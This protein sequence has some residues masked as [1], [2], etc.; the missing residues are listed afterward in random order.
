MATALNLASVTGKIS[1]VSTVG[2]LLV[3]AYVLYVIIRND[4][5][6]SNKLKTKL[7]IFQ[8]LTIPHMTAYLLYYFVL[9]DVLWFHIG[10]FMSSVIFYTINSLNLEI[11]SLFK[12]VNEKISD[13]RILYAQIALVVVF[14]VCSIGLVLQ[15]IW[16]Y[17]VPHAV[18]LYVQ[19]GVLAF[20]LITVGYDSNHD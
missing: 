13:K 5:G 3:N 14:V 15:I 11:L 9:N 12:I 10:G 8:L 19:Y 17:S 1:I 2:T 16:S 18:T 7:L 20:S 6:A 4:V